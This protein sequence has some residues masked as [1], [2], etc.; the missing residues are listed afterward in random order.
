MIYNTEGIRELLKPIPW[1]LTEK[2][3]SETLQVWSS[4]VCFDQWSFWNQLARALFFIEMHQG[5][6]PHTENRLNQGK[7][8]GKN[9]SWWA[10][11]ASA[12]HRC[13]GSSS[14]GGLVLSSKQRQ[15]HNRNNGSGKQSSASETWICWGFFIFTKQMMSWPLVMTSFCESFIKEIWVS[16]VTETGG[17]AETTRCFWL[18]LARWAT[19][20]SWQFNFPCWSTK[21]KARDIFFHLHY[22]NRQEEEDDEE[23]EEGYKVYTVIVRSEKLFLLYMEYRYIPCVKPLFS[24]QRL[25]LSLQP[26]WSAAQLHSLHLPFLFSDQ[27]PGALAQ[28]LALHHWFI[29]HERFYAACVKHT[30]TEIEEKKKL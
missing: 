26:P 15:A 8:W 18:L 19:K 9:Y 27:T 29:S 21:R 16:R 12:Q 25:L 7:I 17:W 4:N 3:A 5:Q 30:M 28:Q 20:I 10:F 24:S 11:C 23:K 6:L 22:S 2:P 1:S 14:T 13:Q